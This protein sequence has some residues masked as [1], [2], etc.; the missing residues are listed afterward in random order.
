MRSLDFTQLPT[1][2]VALA[3]SGA[4]HSFI[5]LKLVSK[6]VL[7]VLPGQSMLVALADGSNVEASKTCI[8]SLVFCADTGRAVSCPLEC[9]GLSCLNHDVVLGHDLLQHVNPAINWEACTVSVEYVGAI[10]P[11]VLAA[12]PVE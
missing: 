9:C 10:K 6:H 4:M 11:L 3:D 1:A 5:F 12:L 2:A 7:T 8:V